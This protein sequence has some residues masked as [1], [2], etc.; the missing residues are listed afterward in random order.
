MQ[1]LTSEMEEEAT[2]EALWAASRSQKRKE[3]DFSQMSSRGTQ[4]CQHPDALV[5]AI[6][7]FL[8]PIAR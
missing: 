1:L 2:T 3:I 8:P 4:P 7:Y 5:R 6:L